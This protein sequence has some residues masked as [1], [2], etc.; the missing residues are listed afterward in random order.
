MIKK[1]RI[2]FWGAIIL[3]LI[4]G[5]NCTG[6]MPK[7]SKSEKTS[8]EPI[9]LYMVQQF[10][11]SYK[12][13]EVFW[14][15][16]IMSCSNK[17]KLTIFEILEFGLDKEGNFKEEMLSEGRFIAETSDFLDCAVYSPGKFITVK[18]TVEG[19]REGRIEE[20]PYKFPVIK[21][22]KINLIGSNPTGSTI[23]S[24]ETLEEKCSGW[25]P[26]TYPCWEK[27]W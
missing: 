12:G 7:F 20:R 17:E 8:K 26:W 15:G 13:E 22:T 24:K 1:I 25:H 9:P 16:K 10:P 18:G 14:G 21:V 27:S 2:L 23:K 4:F 6:K 19:I 11:Q 5:T 3:G